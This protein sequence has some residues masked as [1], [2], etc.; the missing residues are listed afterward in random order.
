MPSSTLRNPSTALRAG[1]AIGGGDP[2]ALRRRQPPLQFAAAVG[3]LEQPLPAVVGAAMLH[4]EPLPHELAQNP[5]QALLRDAQDAEQLADRHLR[6]AA[7]E[8]HD[9]VM[10]PPEAVL[11][12]DRV[13][14]GGE[15]AIGEEQQLD[16]LANRLVARLPAA[17]PRVAG[18]GY[19]MSA[20][21]TY[22][23]MSGTL[24][25]AFAI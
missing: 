25:T 2:G 3:Q 7:D 20:M 15:V 1:G 10:R 12:E 6:M 13:G 22:F 9:P 4:D 11:R 8:M 21:L 16:A 19:F 14:L 23:A 5:V 17:R 24:E 18:V